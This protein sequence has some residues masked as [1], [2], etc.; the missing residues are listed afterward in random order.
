MDARQRLVAAAVTIG[1]LCLAK[2][3][4][5]GTLTAA[6]RKDLA[7]IRTAI[8]KVHVPVRR[9]GIEDAEQKL[10]D[11]EKRLEIFTKD[12]GLEADDPRIVSLRKQIT[13]RRESIAKTREK[14]TRGPK[15]PD[16]AA[17]KSTQGVSFV[18][19]I[20]PILKNHCLSC[21]G[22]DAKG[23]LRLDSYAAMERGG[24]SGPLLT[25]G[26]ADN[27][28]LMAR[29]VVQSE[30]R[31]PKGG[32]PLSE[33]ECLKIAEWI[34]R[35]AKFDGDDPNKTL[36]KLAA[37]ATPVVARPLPKTKSGPRTE[38]PRPKGNETIAFSQDI[39]PILVE[40]CLRCHSGNDPKGGLS[41]ESFDTLWA[42][43]KSGQVILPGDLAKSRLW[44]LVGEQKPFKMPPDDAVIKRS[45]WMKIK[46]WISE[47]ASFDGS[48]TKQRLRSLVPSE[49]ERRKAEL[50]QT[51]PAQLRQRLR[52]RSDEQWRR[53]FPKLEPERIEND[54]FLIYGNVP[55]ERLQEV[56]RWAAETLRT[57][58]EFLGDHSAPAFKGG[59]AVFVL[60]NRAS[61]DE[62]TQ[63]V[64][65]REL[66]SALH[67]SAN[68][69][70][71]LK[72]AYVVI[73]DRDDSAA[74]D[75][76]STR[77]RLSEQITGALLKRADKKLPDW[78]IAGCGRVVA[79]GGSAAA[80][81][82]IDWPA[83]FR[84]TGS[85][86]RT[87]DLLA[88]GTFSSAAIGDV[89]E[90]FTGFLIEKRGKGTF[91]RFLGQLQNG[92]IQA[93]AFRDV[94]GTDLRTIA[95]EFLARADQARRAEK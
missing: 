7:S 28:L 46:T 57:S 54:A 85:L 59:L 22:A 67:G 14:A 80:L 9:D 32:E 92:S 37:A 31:M 55:T 38:M 66:P 65:K 79:A 64:A 40:N 74:Q 24:K 50:A 70:P 25:I 43:G 77:A 82:A 34:N 47:G 44:Q 30:A 51:S 56:A 72:D 26:D 5:A 49:I 76:S 71:D 94:Y 19:Q 8:Y 41:M 95:E 48:D 42:G 17:R 20:A 45:Q 69:T 13:S 90:A 29:L 87:D 75:P 2:S 21:H 84:L 18:K 12:A 4:F 78:L 61:F 83:V 52:T 16:R 53:T 39:A 15:T 27:S 81:A 91:G 35:G 58:Q 36:D 73:E 60:K 88:D 1:V 62:F 23:G 33:M 3:S 86:E 63:T 68:V 10:T 89:S 6:Q 11:A 93:D